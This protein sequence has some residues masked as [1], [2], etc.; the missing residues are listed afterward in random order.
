MV[1]G[2]S[3]GLARDLRDVLEQAVPPTS[4]SIEITFGKLDYLQRVMVLD[5]FMVMDTNGK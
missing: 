3:L 1:A 5:S 4:A 2:E